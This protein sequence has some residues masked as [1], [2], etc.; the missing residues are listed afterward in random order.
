MRRASRIRSLWT[1]WLE[2]PA[3]ADPFPRKLG[4]WLL[5]DWGH[6][7]TG[8]LTLEL[9]AADGGAGLLFVGSEVPDRAAPADAVI[10]PV[11]GKDVWVDV[12]PR[13]FRY[14]YLA[15]L[16][17]RDVPEVE[18]VDEELARQLAPAGSATGGVFGLTPPLERSKAEMTIRR[19]WVPG[20]AR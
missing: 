18:L 7:V 5:F 13:T 17:L 6:E 16:E 4:S 12:H 11:P 10:V 3:A 9:A 15:G 8:F 14:A 20:D 2:A 19:H 1:G